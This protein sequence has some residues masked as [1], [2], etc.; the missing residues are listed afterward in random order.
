MFKKIVSN[1]S[2][3]PAIIWKLSRYDLSLKSE[4]KLI[5]KGLFSLFA[6]IT[7]LASITLYAPKNITNSYNS[8]NEFYN[9]A[10][11]NDIYY[12]KT[13]IF[14]LSAIWII[15]LIRLFRILFTIKE[16][17]KIRQLINSGII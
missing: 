15:K 3:S 11:L 10:F 14:F 1:L 7:I 13:L 16:I 12:L 6:L 4:L 17:K 9:Y 5:K 8:A 2:F